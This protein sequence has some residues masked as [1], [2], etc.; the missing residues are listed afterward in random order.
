MYILLLE[1]LHLEADK[2]GTSLLVMVFLFGLLGNA[3]S[4]LV[5][6]ATFYQIWKNR[7][8]QGYE[9]IPY[10]IGLFSAMMWL[11]YAIF[12]TIKLVPLRSNQYGHLGFHSRPPSCQ[13]AFS[14]TRSAYPSG[15]CGQSCCPR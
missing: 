6:L 9:S 2:N 12:T 4:V 7:T 10:A 5:C 3:I 11:F 8:S 14:G 15:P 13:G 1:Q